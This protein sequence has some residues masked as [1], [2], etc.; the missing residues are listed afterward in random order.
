MNQAPQWI[1]WLQ[2]APLAME[3]QPIDLSAA[4][5][6]TVVDMAAVLDRF[7]G[8]DEIVERLISIYRQD[9]PGWMSRTLVALVERDTQA[10]VFAA[11]RLH[12]LLAH[13]EPSPAAQTAGRLEQ[14]ARQADFAAAQTV[15][16]RLEAELAAFDQA[17]QTTTLPDVAAL[18]SRPSLTPLLVVGLVFVTSGASWRRSG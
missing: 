5:A 7:G 1:L 14:L 4:A 17:Y 11:H 10:L 12:G 13:F 6:T 8:D 18:N 2:A 15:F 3:P 9:W 16:G